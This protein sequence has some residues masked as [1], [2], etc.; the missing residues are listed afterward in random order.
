MAREIKVVNGYEDCDVEWQNEPNEVHD[1]P[2]STP[3]GKTVLNA[4]AQGDNICVNLDDGDHR[5]TIAYLEA[6]AKEYNLIYVKEDHR[7]L[8]GPEPEIYCDAV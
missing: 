1:L 8:I 4:V 3:T 6:M 2:R 5:D 7:I